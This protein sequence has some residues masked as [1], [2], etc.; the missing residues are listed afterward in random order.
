MIS[1][2]VD[3]KSDVK[4]PEHDAGKPLVLFG[5]MLRGIQN[6]MIR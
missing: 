2:H 1:G 6:K 3:L 4:E 5:I